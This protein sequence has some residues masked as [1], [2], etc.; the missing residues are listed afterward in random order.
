MGDLLAGAERPT[1]LIPS[2]LSLIERVL[3]SQYIIG[4]CA[5]AG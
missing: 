1:I 2:F 5:I 4:I 3:T